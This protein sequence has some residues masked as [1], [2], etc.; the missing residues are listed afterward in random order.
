VPAP[1]VEA[2]DAVGAGDTF[3]GALAAGLLARLDLEIAVRRA[4][5]AASLS[6][7]RPGARSGMPTTAEL[8][9]FVRAR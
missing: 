7:T 4:V 2:V 6:T 5:A 9:A 3:A 8:E 1:S